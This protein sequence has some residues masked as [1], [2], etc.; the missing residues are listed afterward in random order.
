MCGGNGGDALA[1][2]GADGDGRCAVVNT[3]DA[4]VRHEV[5][6]SGTSV[7]DG[8]GEEWV[9]WWATVRDRNG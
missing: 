6:R 1:S 5:V 3:C 8:C 2:G 4:C 7:G 9:G